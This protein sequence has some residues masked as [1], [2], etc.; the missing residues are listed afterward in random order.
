MRNKRYFAG[1]STYSNL[2]QMICCRSVIKEV[3]NKV[4]LEQASQTAD[5][6]GLQ[7][8]DRRAI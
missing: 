1:S 4:F 8:S 5:E 2:N 6:L 3:V 7:P